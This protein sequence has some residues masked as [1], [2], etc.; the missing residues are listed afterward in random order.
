MSDSELV[1]E[2]AV[3]DVEAAAEAVAFAMTAATL[4]NV[5]M[6]REQY[7]SPKQGG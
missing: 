6:Q 1:L 4:G 5:G 7:F 3:V 2:A